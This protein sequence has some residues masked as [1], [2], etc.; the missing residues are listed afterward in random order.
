MSD[1]KG[2][3][4]Q[5]NLTWSHALGTGAV[6]QATSADTP[7]DPF[8]LRT[9][10]GVQ[11]WD[12]ALVF[13]IFAVYQPK[14]GQ[15][16]HGWAGHL[17]GG[18]TFAPV[19]ATGSG[20]PVTLGTV[21]GGGQAFGEGDSVNFVG[22]GISENA[23]PIGP[24]PSGSRNNTPGSNG[25][26]TSGFGVNM[27]AN[28]AAAYNNIRQPILGYDSK[29]G[30][31]GF[32]RGLPYWNVDFSMKKNFR[33]TERVNF[34]AQVIFTNL[35]NNVTFYDPGPG[36]LI[37]TSSPASFGTLPGQGNT[38]RQMEFGFRVLF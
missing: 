19:F 36:D 11:E 28:P 27:F 22:Y 3:T 23:I 30:G 6:L 32:L 18:W 29:D 7:P 4:L 14:W 10:Y 24:L 9:G 31:F 37:D 5:S 1:W 25:V 8:N 33:I 26:G 20:L 35:F 34:E 17:L 21:N 15:G 16:Q 2:L 13:N 12:R 38:P